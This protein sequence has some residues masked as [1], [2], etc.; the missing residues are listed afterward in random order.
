LCI[1]FYSQLGY[2]LA[3][4]TVQ[5]HWK[6]EMRRQI[7]AATP[8]DALVAIP[9]AA[10][11]RS[12]EWEEPGREFSLQGQMY[13]VVRTK[14][15]NGQTVLLCVNDKKEAQLVEQMNKASNNR[16]QQGRDARVPVF[17]FICDLFFFNDMVRGVFS[18]HS[19]CVYNR[20][21]ASLLA[22]SAAIPVPP[23]RG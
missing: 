6:K 23:P 20:Y 3:F 4:K 21:T 16:Q 2:F 9:L 19:T 5:Y 1:F 13:D 8:D 14:T 18:S 7:L 10:R 11:I 12:I 22:R 17:Q 15:I